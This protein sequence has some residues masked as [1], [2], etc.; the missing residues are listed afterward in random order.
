VLLSVSHADARPAAVIAAK[1]ARVGAPGRDADQCL[2]PSLVTRT[3]G[4]VTPATA[5]QT[6]TVAM[7]LGT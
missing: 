1:V 4:R 7:P 3:R 2:P 5:H 6:S